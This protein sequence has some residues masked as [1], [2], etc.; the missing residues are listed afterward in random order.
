M[1]LLCSQFAN[2]IDLSAPIEYCI[3]KCP[4][5][6]NIPTTPQTCKI[7]IAEIQRVIVQ[8]AKEADALRKRELE[9]KLE[10]RKERGDRVGA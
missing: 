6:A 9:E 10:D 4:P 1:S 7:R 8:K 2:K 5:P 3:T